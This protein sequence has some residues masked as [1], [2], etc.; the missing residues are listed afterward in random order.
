MVATT[1]VDREAGSKP[2]GSIVEQ[3][4]LIGTVEAVD[5]AGSTVTV[6]GPQNVVTMSVENPEL[7][8]DIDVGDRVTATYIKAVAAKVEAARKTGGRPAS[9]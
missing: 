4:E 8:Q 9:Q 7:L 1:E 5:K 3:I 2:A 6:R